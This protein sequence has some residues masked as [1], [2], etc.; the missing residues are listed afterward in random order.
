M[1]NSDNRLL[2][3]NYY[4]NVT[5]TDYF[6][7]YDDAIE[8]NFSKLNHIAISFKSGYCPKE[9]LEKINWE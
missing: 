8:M 4:E 7:E 2:D 5:K 9:F 3:K 6:S 1:S